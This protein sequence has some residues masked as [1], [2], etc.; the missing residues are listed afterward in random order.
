MRFIRSLAENPNAVGD[1]KETDNVGRVV[2]V[3]IIGRYAVT[4]W[5]DD[6]VAEVKVTH[7][8]SADK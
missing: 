1:F 2:Q 7:I 8:Q 3:K 5:A 4:F 6:A